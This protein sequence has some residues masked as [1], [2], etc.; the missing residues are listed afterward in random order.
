MNNNIDHNKIFFRQSRRTFLQTGLLSAAI[1]VSLG[2]LNVSCTGE[3]TP[4]IGVIEPTILYSSDFIPGGF[5]C[6]LAFVAD[7]HY[8]PNHY[9]NWGSKQFRHT[10]ER[11]RDLIVTLNDEAPDLSIHGG[12]VI[13][14]GTAFMPPLDEYIEQLDYEKKFIDAFDHPAIPIVG[15][16]EV[17]D[18]YYESESELD[19]W[20]ERFGSLYRYTDINGWRL[21]CLNT[22][23]P[24]PGGE[25][26]VYGIDDVQLRWL[27]KVLDDAGS[28][29]L[30]VLLFAHIPPD[31]YNCK[32]TED[33]GKVIASAGCVKGLMTG[34]THRNERHNFHGIPVLVRASNVASPLAYTLVYPYPDGR[35]IVVQKSQHFPFI[36][37][38]SNHFEERLQGN[39]EDRYYT[40]NGSSEL[41][42]DGFRVIGENAV[43]SI[44]DGHLRLTSEKG[45]GFL[46][47]D[48]PG[49]DN[50]RLI[51]S[52]VKEGATHMGVVAYANDDCSDRID[53]VI[54]SEYG[55]DG[56]MFLASH[57]RNQK[58]TLDVSWFNIADG[59]SYQ[60][61]LE[62][63]N[64]T[65]TFSP[66]NMP[67]LSA[68]MQG[69][70][71]GKF[72]VFAENGT[73]LV[74]DIRLEK[75]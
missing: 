55:P 30:N 12:D 8:W 17:P 42:L 7:H 24:D 20:K 71:T 28:R 67:M 66:K 44:Q 51:V 16:H 15:N 45:K 54:T 22:M 2:I 59:I 74:T 46:L 39:E 47:I 61:I 72:G 73:I 69:S 14:A 27:E 19:R 31:D 48:K 38:I 65:V 36:D 58:K 75:I 33:F 35:I 40:L 9:K 6:K 60:F 50:V 23:V 62:V 49:L 70:P 57:E 1:P 13:D 11:M 63:R 29:N 43:A 26:P 34:H 53:G 37:Y 4:G 5:S 32:T 41:S 64:G 3:D 18:A 68:T 56:N 10:E 25:R 21:V 52:A